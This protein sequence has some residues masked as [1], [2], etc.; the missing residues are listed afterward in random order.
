MA[1]AAARSTTTLP[2][3]ASSLPNTYIGRAVPRQL[4][5][6]AHTV[7]D[8][9]CSF[10]A[11]SLGWK[12]IA[13]EEESQKYKIGKYILETKRIR[14]VSCWENEESEDAD[15]IIAAL[16][17]DAA[18]DL[19]LPP[20]RLP[21]SSKDSLQAIEFDSEDEDECEDLFAGVWSQAL[22]LKRRR[23]RM[24]LDGKGSSGS[25]KLRS[26]SNG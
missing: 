11:T 26:R 10:C 25:G 23:G 24:S 22:A 20:D 13:A 1:V 2:T 3:T 16:P 18:G 5:T 17:F 14:G 21:M 12:Y 6:G 19:P 4:V 7:S 9:S 15:D 8:V